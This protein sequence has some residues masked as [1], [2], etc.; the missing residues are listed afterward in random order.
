MQGSLEGKILPEAKKVTRGV[1]KE[2][3]LPYVTHIYHAKNKRTKFVADL[4]KK[5]YP[6]AVV[7]MDKRLNERDCGIFEGERVEK[8]FSERDDLSNYR[9]RYYWKAPKGESHFEV[10]KRIKSFLLDMKMRHR[11]GHI[12]CVTSAGVLRNLLRI[13]NNLSLRE[14]YSLKIPNLGYFEISL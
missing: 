13:T 9:R 1:V 11:A 12:V 5:K 4:L 2:I 7:L 8:V 10:S 3:S 14:M 6:K